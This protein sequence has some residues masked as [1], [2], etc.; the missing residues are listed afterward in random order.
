MLKQTNHALKKISK[1]SK[2]MHID[3]LEKLNGIEKGDKEKKD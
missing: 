2:S 1:L 3:G